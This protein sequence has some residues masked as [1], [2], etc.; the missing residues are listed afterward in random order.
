MLTGLVVLACLAAGGIAIWAVW[1]KNPAM[2]RGRQLRQAPLRA[3]LDAEPII[4][5]TP[6]RVKYRVPQTGQWSVKN[7]GFMEL[8]IRETG[9][10]IT[11]RS[12]LGPFPGSDWNFKSLGTHMREATELRSGVRRWIS[13]AGDEQLGTTDVVFSAA[14]QTGRVWDLLVGSGVTADSSRPDS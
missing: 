3:A 1:S 2:P 12:R 14:E 11:L 10:Q 7:L 9:F 5:R 13:V 8:V 6:V 4:Y